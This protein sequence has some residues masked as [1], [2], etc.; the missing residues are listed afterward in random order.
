MVQRNVYAPTT[1]TVTF[2]VAVFALEN[3]AV[4]G[5]A[6]SVHVPVPDVG[7]LPARA[8]VSAHTDASGPALDAVGGAFT[9]TVI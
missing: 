7:T 6:T 1:L 3:V 4:P 2:D 8:V 5:P 9:V